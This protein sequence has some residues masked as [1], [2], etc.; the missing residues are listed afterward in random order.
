MS[1]VAGHL[2]HTICSSH[3]QQVRPKRLAVMRDGPQQPC[4]QDQFAVLQENIQCCLL[5]TMLVMSPADHVSNV[6]C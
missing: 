3:Q 1:E 4:E 2:L 5:L 6:S